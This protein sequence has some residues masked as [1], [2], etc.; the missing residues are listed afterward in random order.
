[1]TAAYARK[2]YSG[3]S[4]VTT[5]PTGMASGDSSF[6][7]AASTN[8]SDGSAGTFFVVVDFGLSTQE[9]IECSSRTGLV[10]TVAAS[11]RGKDGTSAVAHSAGCA[12]QQCHSAQDDDEANQVVSAVLG[13]ASAA[14]GDIPVI[15]S[16]AGP[17]TMT[18]LGVGANGSVLSAASATPAYSLAG[19]TGQLLQSAGAA[20]PTFN[21][22][23]LQGI[24]SSSVGVGTTANATYTALGTSATVTVTTGT[25]ALC[26]LTGTI[27][28]LTN[29]IQSW[30]GVAVSG[31]TTVAAA[32]AS[33]MTILAATASNQIGAS[34]IIPFL[35]LTAGSN[36]FTAQLRSG[37][38]GQ[39]AGALNV[40]I[41]IVPI[42]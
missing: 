1:M 13:Q 20:V 25:K 42:N 3:G 10:V 32:D 26:I 7:L 8:W 23:L 15:L 24:A 34:L 27:Y 31:A 22:T 12:V 11:G 6:T 19:A 21:S 35:S 18:R 38:A 4:I 28:N 29:A 14:K 40:L 5:V 9:K 37:S 17:V 33:A 39:T 2:M 36:V 30:L 16:A 41:T